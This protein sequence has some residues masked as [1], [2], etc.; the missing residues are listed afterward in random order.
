V[1]IPG[2]ATHRRVRDTLPHGGFAS[3]SHVARC[4]LALLCAATPVRSRAQTPLATPATFLSGRV[5]LDAGQIAAMERGQAAV[6]VLKTENSRDVAIFGAIVVNV[7]REAFVKRAS[8]MSVALR[9]P[10]RV[11]FGVFSTP[12][13]D[14]DVAPL[15][16]DQQTVKELASCKPGDCKVKL[17]AVDIAHVHDFDWSS[18]GINDQ[19]SDY[20][21]QRMVL[22]VTN[23]RERGNAAMV[24]YDDK[25]SV[26]SS[27][28][29]SALLAES[30][31]I[32]QYV[33]DFHAFLMDY[34]RQRP[35][36]LTDV[37]YW[38]QDQLPELKP[39]V[40]INHLSIYSPP[41]VPNG[42]MIA[43]KQIYADHYFEAAFD[44]MTLLDRTTGDGA[45]GGSIYL[46]DLRRYRF[47]DLPG[48][49][50]NIRGKVIGKLRDLLSSDLTRMK[51]EYEAALKQ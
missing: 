43:Q 10:G 13:A 17:P 19:I 16:L 36:G 14:A 3:A 35:A 33:P 40:L 2:Q 41:G 28:A 29:F 18:P 31:Y 49:L 45:L 38:S 25:G 8:D 7:P 37:I 26:Q 44:L 9:T 42:T 48:G 22:Y 1:K 27:D 20:A 21:R 4:A 12:A 15:T 6:K 50:L 46:L 34:P 39:L 47:D 11:R 32:Y 30:P 24:V 23:Y 51:S 5:G